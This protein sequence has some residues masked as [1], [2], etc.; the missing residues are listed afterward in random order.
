MDGRVSWC[1]DYCLYVDC[2]GVNRSDR[3]AVDDSPNQNC[4]YL[5]LHLEN[6]QIIH[7]LCCICLLPTESNHTMRACILS[8]R[9]SNRNRPLTELVQSVC[10]FLGMAWCGSSKIIVQWI[11]AIVPHWLFVC[12]FVCYGGSLF[13]FVSCSTVLW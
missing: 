11:D 8:Q 1:S 5:I 2:I 10:G 13:C 6:K 7:I 3:N 4:L 9:L 12:L